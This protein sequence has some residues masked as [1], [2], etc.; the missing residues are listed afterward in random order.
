MDRYIKPTESRDDYISISQVAYLLDSS[1]MSIVRW[2][3]WWE[4][5]EFEKPEDLVLPPYYYLNRRRTKYFK[6]SDISILKEFKIKLATTHRG[7]MADFNNAYTGGKA[8]KARC[9]RSGKNYKEI[10]GKLS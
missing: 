2:Y 1:N 7:C 10:R 9:E 3:K 6:K 5:P 8:G 4:S